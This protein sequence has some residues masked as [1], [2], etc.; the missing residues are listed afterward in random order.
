MSRSS[1][2][3][4]LL[5]SVLVV[6]CLSSVISAQTGT[7]PPAASGCQETYLDLYS[8]V[9]AAGSTTPSPN[10]TGMVYNLTTQLGVDNYTVVL[11]TTYLAS[12]VYLQ[13]GVAANSVNVTFNVTVNGS[14][15]SGTYSGSINGTFV[16]AGNFNQ[17][18]L[19]RWS[20]IVVVQ[21]SNLASNCSYT[22]YF[23]IINPALAA[24]TPSSVRGD[25]QFVGLR[26]QT[27]QVHG[28]DGAVYALISDPHVEV[29]TRF[30][31]LQGPR[32]CP[33]MPSTGKMATACWSHAGSYL[34]ELAVKTSAGDRI[35]LVAGSAVDGFS[36]VTV[37]G[38]AL[39][40]DGSSALHYLNN[41]LPIGTI[42]YNNTHELTITCSFFTL[43]VEN[44]DNF[45][46]IRSLS[47]LDGA[48]PRLA[49][50][51]LLGQTWQWKRYSGK[52]KEI[53]GEVD[54]YALDGDDLFGDSFVFS[55]F[56]S[57]PHMQ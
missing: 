40:V 31:F 33:V 20:N 26:G 32:P 36:T 1:V 50:H 5:V 15:A 8:L 19:T 47:V 48:W 35:H 14:P 43:I 17:V 29:N 3:V 24:A 39:S 55:R 45:L 30:L 16:L 49:A 53:E 6:L 13:I 7:A 28:M 9:Y 57:E 2:L 46:N 51:G 38:K 4:S 41:N 12:L 21:F 54:D 23:T 22:D 34:G 25:P 44:I 37:N 18:G 27:F 56:E 42:I 10:S 52:V 11:P